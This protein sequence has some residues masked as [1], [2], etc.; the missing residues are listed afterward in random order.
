MYDRDELAHIV[1]FVGHHLRRFEQAYADRGLRVTGPWGDADNGEPF[2]DLV[3]YLEH[4]DIEGERVLRYPLERN[5]RLLG[6]GDA[7]DFVH[8][9]QELTHSEIARLPRSDQ[10]EDSS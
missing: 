10:A 9:L 2:P 8:E 4:E 7:V 1:A 3:Y 5:G 6:A